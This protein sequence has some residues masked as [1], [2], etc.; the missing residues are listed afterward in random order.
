MFA[1]STGTMPI[2]KHDPPPEDRTKGILHKLDSNWGVTKHVRDIGLS[3]GL[4]WSPDNKIFYF[5]DSY[6]RRVDAFDFFTETGTMSNYYS[7]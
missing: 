4:A 3:N 5:I 1:R 2:Y 7:P 6:T